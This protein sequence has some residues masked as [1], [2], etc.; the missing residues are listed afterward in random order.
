MN[1]GNVTRLLAEHFKDVPRTTVSTQ[2]SDMA[3]KSAQ[4]LKVGVILE[5]EEGL[6]FSDTPDP[7]L[8]TDNLIEQE[9]VNDDYEEESDSEDTQ[10]DDSS[11]L[12]L[13]PKQ[14]TSQGSEYKPSPGKVSKKNFSLK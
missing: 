6:D 13:L 14:G 8:I 7:D 4:L 3:E 10:G 12:S 5:T 2:E 9:Y 11:T 1:L